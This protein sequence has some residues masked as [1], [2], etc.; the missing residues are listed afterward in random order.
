MVSVGSFKISVILLCGLFIYDIFWVFGTNVMVTVAKVSEL[1]NQIL[2]G[3]NLHKLLIFALLSVIWSPSQAH[4]S[5]FSG[6]METKYF[7][8]W[9][10]RLAWNFYCNG[11][12]IRSSFTWGIELSKQDSY[13]WGAGFRYTS[14]MLRYVH[15]KRWRVQWGSFFY[16]SIT[17]P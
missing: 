17:T 13:K 11:P 12:K 8:T 5:C 14:G 1:E 6:S 15:N 9:W 16:K 10:H 2:V 3:V 7:R 4:F